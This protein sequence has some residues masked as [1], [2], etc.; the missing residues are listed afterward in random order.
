MAIICKLSNSSPSFREG[1]NYGKLRWL[2]HHEEI[3]FNAKVLTPFVKLEKTFG[4][5]YAE[6]FLGQKKEKMLKKW[7]EIRSDKIKAD[8][9]YHSLLISVTNQDEFKFGIRAAESACSGRK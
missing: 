1:F 4:T 3:G 9:S 8:A 7:K 5:E 2:A 6:K